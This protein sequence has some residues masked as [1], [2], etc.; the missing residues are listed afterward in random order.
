MRE[1]HR[2]QYTLIEVLEEFLLLFGFG[3]YEMWS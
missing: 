3:H 1:Q 2:K